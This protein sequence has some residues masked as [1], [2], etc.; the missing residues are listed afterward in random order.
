MIRTTKRKSLSERTIIGRF[1]DELPTVHHSHISVGSAGWIG[2]QSLDLL[3]HLESGDDEAKDN[4]DS[5]KQ[6]FLDKHLASCIAA[7]LFLH[8]RVSIRIYTQ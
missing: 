7:G 5:G 3:H 1:G 4:V 2:L 6:D 8:P